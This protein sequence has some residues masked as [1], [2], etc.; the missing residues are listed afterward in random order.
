VILVM[1]GSGQISAHLR[2]KALAAS[3][4]DRITINGRFD[5]VAIVPQKRGC[6]P[7]PADTTTD[8]IP[9]T[10]D[11]ASDDGQVD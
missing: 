8:S 6:A 3:S 4:V 10:T 11:A 1:S 9:D 2:G 7:E 5:G